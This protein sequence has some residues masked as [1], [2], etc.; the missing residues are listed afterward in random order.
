MRVHQKIV[1]IAAIIVPIA[2]VIG[3]SVWISPPKTSIQSAYSDSTSQVSNNSKVYIEYAALEGKAYDKAFLAGMIVHHGSAMNMAEQASAST[4]RSEILT[5]ADEINNVQS[6]EMLTMIT[7]QKEYGF[8]ITSAHNMSNMNP[9]ET[10]DETMQMYDSLIGLSDNGFDKKFL[11]A[12]IQHHQDAIDMSMPAVTQS[13]SE[14]VKYLAK[15]VVDTQR[16][17][18]DQMKQWQKDWQL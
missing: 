10:M 17:E 13:N 2:V 11:E 18:I 16:A 6:Q 9:G 14:R 8:P 12:M 15:N 1:I 4:K 5:L 3:A 7:L